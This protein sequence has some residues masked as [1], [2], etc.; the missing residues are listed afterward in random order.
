MEEF[1]ENLDGDDE[2]L[3]TVF[4]IA[5]DAIDSIKEHAP[6]YLRY[7]AAFLTKHIFK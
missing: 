4:D 1:I 7:A 3:S 6:Q 5:G 2:I